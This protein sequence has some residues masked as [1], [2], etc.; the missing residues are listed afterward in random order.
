MLFYLGMIS[1]DGGLI[2]TIMEMCIAGDI[3]CQYRY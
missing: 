2:T 1:S 3:G